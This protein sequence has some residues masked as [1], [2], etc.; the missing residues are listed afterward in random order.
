MDVPDNQPDL[1]DEVR[2]DAGERAVTTLDLRAA[3]VTSVIWA[4]GYGFDYSWVQLPVLDSF[5]YPIQQRGVTGFP[6]L[7]FVGMDWL[8]S[9]KS[10]ILLGVGE[11]LYQVPL[12][13]T[14]G[15]DSATRR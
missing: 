7:Y 5:G 4:T 12:R 14:H 1:I 3:G 8:Y 6:G 11:D 15:S 2:S 10:G 9:R 13:V